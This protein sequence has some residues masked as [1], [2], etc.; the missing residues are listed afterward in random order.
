MAEEK[1]SGLLGGLFS[2]LH[3]DARGAIS[4]MITFFAFGCMVWAF[5][6]VPKYLAKLTDKDPQHC[7]E[8]TEV[9]GTPVKFNQSTGDVAAVDLKALRHD[10]NKETPK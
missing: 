8:L 3:P 10:T 7:W 2:A 6:A 9:Q 1:G 5:I 4:G